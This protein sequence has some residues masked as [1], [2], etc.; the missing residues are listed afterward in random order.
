MG[1]TFAFIAS[2][3]VSKVKP[4]K[5]QL[6]CYLTFLHFLFF[7][8]HRHFLSLSLTQPLL[9][10]SSFFPTLTLDTYKTFSP[11]P[12]LNAPYTLFSSTLPLT[13]NTFFPCFFFF[14]SIWY[15]ILHTIKFF[16]I[17]HVRANAMS[18]QIFLL[19]SVFISCSYLKFFSVHFP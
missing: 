1:G 11:H 12:I 5:F 10:S 13:L 9:I 16:W 17:L 7:Y 2:S 8:Y 6:F 14:Q 15:E 3:V 4:Y 19:L 18:I